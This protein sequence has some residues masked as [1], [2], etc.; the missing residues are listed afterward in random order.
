[1]K[2]ELTGKDLAKK[3]ENRQDPLFHIG[4]SFELAKG[5]D[6]VV[7]LYTCGEVSITENG[8][9]VDEKDVIAKYDTDEKLN[10]A[11]DKGILE[12]QLN[13]WYE[14]QIFVNDE[15]ME[16]PDWVVFSFDEALEDVKNYLDSPEAE[17]D[18]T[19]FKED[20]QLTF[21][22]EK[23]YLSGEVWRYEVNSDGTRAGDRYSVDSEDIGNKLVLGFLVQK[24]TKQGMLVG[25]EFY[26]VQSD[27]NKPPVADDTGE[28]VYQ[29][30]EQEV[31][32]KIKA[33]FPAD[34]YQNNAW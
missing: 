13:N 28:Y 20:N 16:T 26:P 14:P 6:F 9:W 22:V 7:R 8:E 5:E 2:Y 4:E 24:Y 3:Y 17:K 32:A 33:D 10:E 11:F 30:N 29:N 34:K 31:L 15:Y 12:Y 21:T 18:I 19:K 1:M 27:M 23:E 25:L